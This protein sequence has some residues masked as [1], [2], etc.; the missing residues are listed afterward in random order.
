MSIRIGKLYISPDDIV[1][2]T[3]IRDADDFVGAYVVKYLGDINKN[4]IPE[5]TWFNMQQIGFM[6]LYKL[7][8]DMDEELD[9]L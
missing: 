1:M 3:E 7:H 9:T 8:I 2:V 5:G 6:Q 4:Y